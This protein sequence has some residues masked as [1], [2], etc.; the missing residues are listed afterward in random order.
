MSFSA[1][2]GQEVQGTGD[3]EVLRPVTVLNEIDRTFETGISLFCRRWAAYIIMRCAE[4]LGLLIFLAKIVT[5]CA[6]VQPA[7]RLEG[8]LVYPPAPSSGAICVW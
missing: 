8:L 4:G 3:R 2:G 5:C 7:T 6:F 1:V